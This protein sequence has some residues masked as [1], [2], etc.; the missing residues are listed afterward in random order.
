MLVAGYYYTSWFGL[1]GLVSL[2]IPTLRFCPYYVPFG[3]A[4]NTE[5][6]CAGVAGQSFLGEIGS[7]NATQLHSAQS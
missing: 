2:L 7:A 3:L 1:I 5:E 6:A 4:I